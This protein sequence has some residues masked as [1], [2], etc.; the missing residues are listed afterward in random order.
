MIIWQF[1]VL[2]VA[3]HVILFYSIF[4]IYFK[5][6]LVH[7][8]TPVTTGVPAPSKRLVLFVADGL[9]ADKFF[10][11]D[12]SGNYRAPYLRNI[13][14]NSGAWGISHTRV[15]TESR[16][17]H[18]AIIAG[19]YEDV[20]AIAKGWKEN[21]VQFDSVFNESYHTWS[22]GSP[23]ILPMFAKGASGDHVIT[24]SY[25][26]ELEDFGGGDMS[27]LDNW[28][29]DNA[30]AFFTSAST[31]ST[32]HEMLQ[33]DKV[34]FFFHL[35]GIDTHGHAHKPHSLAYS[36]NINL[37]DSEIQKMV[38]MIE[39]F[40]G[41][42][43]LTSYVMTADHGMT[44]W[45]SHGA[46]QPHETL[47]PLVTWGAGIRKPILTSNCGA[48]GDK[49]CTAWNL[50]SV[51]RNDVQQVDIAP[52]MSY[53]IGVPYP[54]NSIGI[55]PIDLL[56]ASEGDKA[57]A[58][59]ANA[60][61]ILAQFQVKMEQVKERTISVTFRPFLEL[62]ESEKPPKEL[63]TVRHI[64]HL[65]KNGQI[66]EAVKDTQRLIDTALRGLQYYQTYDRLFLGASIVLGFLG[67][68]SYTFCILVFEYTNIGED[69][70]EMVERN[71]TFTVVF[72]ALAI[73]ITVLLY[74]QSLPFMCYTYCLLPVLLWYKF[75]QGWSVMTEAFQ[76]AVE[77]Q[78]LRDIIVSMSFCAVGL[79]I[80]ILS[81]Y[82][83]ELLSLGLVALSAWP[84]VTYY[85]Y[86]LWPASTA[87]CIGWSVTCLLV[88][89]FPILPVASKHTQYH[90]VLISGV[91]TVLIGFTLVFKYFTTVKH[92]LKYLWILQLTLI[93]FSVLTVKLTSD[94]IIGGKGL[95]L[96]CQFTSWFVLGVSIV[97]PMLSPTTLYHRLMSL[98]LS[99]FS[100]YLLLSITY[101][102]LF[103]MSLISLL[104]F[105]LQM[106]FEALDS[107]GRNVSE[108][109][110]FREGGLVTDDLESPTFS[111]YL[112]LADLRRAFFF[113]F[114]MIVAFFGTGNIA[115][116]N[117][118][119][120]STVYCFL[121]VFHPFV[122][123][124]LMFFKILIPFLI[125]TCAFRA[126]HVLTRA[127]LRSLFLLVFIMSD[128]MGLHFFFLVKDYGSWLD[129]GTTISHYVIVMLLNIFMLV[130]TG[131]SHGLTCWS[132]MW[133][134]K[135]DKQS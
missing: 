56:S 116:I 31:N 109:V 43:S 50:E 81:F 113:V 47:T 30:E 124:A 88:A 131:I 45:G 102:G 55:L 111:R 12:I 1:I 35:L 10:E 82:Y 13:I 23:D 61:Q 72:V 69:R 96:A 97:L 64:K 3:V 119:D 129:I 133:L 26:S 57:T 28:V 99:M 38:S 103:L 16:P 6:P 36:K 51:K 58:L 29:F 117:S 71:K 127:P 73:I 122:M 48:Y 41:N 132:L 128:F 67:W 130:L 134:I 32:L 75:F 14:E 66:E 11:L 18:V 24:N 54:M 59:L 125:V 85:W 27:I 92:S 84:L 22:W 118:F 21:P 39:N 33:R 76:A 100:P 20:S 123:G 120:P 25:S 60:E 101:E 79:E 121:T 126:V 110:D 8:M 7:G 91:L 34:V 89:V 53:L 70:V 65:I 87:T 112:E 104:Y 108:N 2:G 86:G 42:D 4:D 5:S 114:Y 49:F 94:S 105:W 19:F 63:H 44:D 62:V 107:S 90:L 74:V 77:N 135:G 95:P 93:S 46:G 17:G 52:L 40:Y 115:S 9:R 106:E 80:V 83:R 15:P 78:L 68:M 37:V 98:I